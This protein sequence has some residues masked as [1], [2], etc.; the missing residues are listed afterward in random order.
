MLECCLQRRDPAGALELSVR[1]ALNDLERA[2][3]Q[4]CDRVVQIHTAAFIVVWEARATL[5]WRITPRAA[6]A[7][8]ELISFSHDVMHGAQRDRSAEGIHTVPVARDYESE[9]N[10]ALIVFR[11]WIAVDRSRTTSHRVVQTTECCD[12]N[13]VH[14]RDKRIG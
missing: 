11:G 3:L 8:R 4:S 10:G 12:G 5:R 7:E 6:A 13:K 2:R 9:R 14:G 1:F